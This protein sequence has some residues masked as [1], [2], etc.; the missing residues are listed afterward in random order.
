[1]TYDNVTTSPIIA[2]QTGAYCY[3]LDGDYCD[4]NYG[5]NCDLSNGYLCTTSD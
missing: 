3:S 4:S 5:L 1:M 2:D